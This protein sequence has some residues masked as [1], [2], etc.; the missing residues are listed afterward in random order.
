MEKL[1]TFPNLETKR[2]RLRKLEEADY[3]HIIYLRSDAE[4]NRFVQRPKAEN[5]EDALAFIERISLEFLTGKSI[6]WVITQKNAN[7]MLGSICLWNFSED[8]TTAELGYDL[9]PTVQGRGFMD[10]AMKRIV[11]FGF[12]EGKFQKIEAF[13][14]KNNLPS[15]KLL[16]KNHFELKPLRSDPENALNLIFELSEKTYLSFG[17]KGK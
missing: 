4:V 16:K 10:E 11:K 13:T 2:L 6:Y 15:I 17:L 8:G 9:A 7:E 12:E 3:E 1:N 14:Q 5:R